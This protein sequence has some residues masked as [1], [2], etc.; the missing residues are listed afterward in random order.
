M[1]AL[2]VPYGNR[3]EQ[4]DFYH[5]Y[6]FQSNS[7]STMNRGVFVEGSFLTSSLALG[8]SLSDPGLADR[9]ILYLSIHRRR[10]RFHLDATSRWSNLAVLNGVFEVQWGAYIASSPDSR[11][12]NLVS[13]P[14]P[15]E[16]FKFSVTN[17]VCLVA[18]F[19][20]TRRPMLVNVAS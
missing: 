15:V 1:P 9:L 14:A 2:Y 4:R 3:S 10:L 16:W 19:G 5:S 17:I 11:V 13:V 6:R 7:R 12:F 20:V 18:T 8:E